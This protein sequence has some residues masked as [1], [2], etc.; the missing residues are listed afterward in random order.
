MLTQSRFSKALPLLRL[1]AKRWVALKKES[2][3]WNLL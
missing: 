2:N 3:I 1:Q